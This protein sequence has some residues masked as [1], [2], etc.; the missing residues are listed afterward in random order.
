LYYDG[1]A[2]KK[3]FNFLAVFLFLII[4]YGVILSLFTRLIN[5]L[6]LFEQKYW[7]GN[8]I[9]KTISLL[10]AVF[11]LLT[12]AMPTNAYAASNDYAG[13]WAEETIQLWLNEGRITGYPDGSFKPNG[14]ITRAEFVTMVNKLFSFN[15]TTDINFSDV[16]EDDWYYQEVQKAFK[17]G[18]ITGVS[19]TQ[20]APN[21]NLTRE[22]AAVIVAK[23]MK[24]EINAEAAG[25]FT[26]NNKISNW[27]L[28]FVG[29]AA[30]SELIKGYTEDNTFKPQ[31][32]ITRAE[33]VVTL[34]RTIDSK[35]LTVDEAGTV[36]ENQ[37]VRN[38]YITKNVGDGDVTLKNVTVTGELLVEGGGLNT[39]TIEDSKI[40]KLTTNK[41]DGK[42]RILLKGGSEVDLTSILSGATLEQQDLTGDGFADVVIEEN[43]NK[44]QTITIKADIKE[45]SF[46]A[47]IKVNVVTGVIES[48]IIDEAA[49]DLI[50]D[51]G[52]GV[53]VLSAV[54]N[55]KVSFTGKGTIEK[56]EV[57]ADGVTFEKKPT[58]IIT[59]PPIGGGGGGGGNN[60]P[61][62]N[63]AVTGV[64]LDRGTM[65][66]T[67]GGATGTLIATVAPATATNKTVTWT[68]SNT[69]VATVANGV[70]TPISA[71]T[72]IITVTTADGSKTATCNITVNNLSVVNVTNINII[73]ASTVKFN[74]DISGAT[75]K[76]NGELLAEETVSGENEITVPLMESGINN[77]L[78]IEKPGYIKFETSNVVYTKPYDAV[79]TLGEWKKD[80][81]QPKTWEI[82]DNWI[83]HTTTKEKASNSWYDWQ[84]RG[85]V[86]N[87]GLTDKWKVETQIE[88]TD[89]LLYGKGVRTSLWIQVDGFGGAPNTQNNVL[90]WAIL[91][92]NNDATDPNNPIMGWESWDS[93][94]KWIPIKDLAVEKGIYTLTMIYDN[95][96][97]SQYIN[98]VL[99]REY[100]I[101]T[102]D[103][104]RGLTSPS[105]LIVQS[106]TFGDE[107]TVKWKV[108]TVEFVMPNINV[109]DVQVLNQS[110]IKF[111][112]D[113]SGAIIK[114][115]G[116]LIAEETVSGENNITVPLMESD[117]NN[118]LTLEKT[119]Y[120]KFE[121]GNVVYRTPYDSVA[122]LGE[123]NKDRTD[124]KTWKIVNGWITHTTN[125]ETASNSWYNWQGK[126]AFTSVGLSDKWKVETQVELTNELLNGT[127]VRTSL[128]IQVDG[129]NGVAN[130]QNNVLDWSILGYIND[131]TNSI[132][133][134][135][136]WDSEKGLWVTVDDVEVQEGIYTLT[137]IYDSGTIY[138]YINGVLVRD[139][140]IKTDDEYSEL[141]APSYLIVQSRTFG[142]EYTVNWKVPTVDYVSQYPVNSKFISTNAEL[143]EAINNQ[144]DNQT[145][146]IK[147]NKTEY[148]VPSGS[149][150]ISG[151][152]GWYLPITASNLSIIGIDN[153]IL[154]STETSANGAWASQ[155]FITVFGDNVTID[156]VKIK[157]KTEANKAIEVLGKDFK[158]KNSELLETAD[159]YS[160]A[161]YF[162]NPVKDEIKDM[163]NIV[164][165]NV[166]MTNS[167]VS[168]RDNAWGSGAMSGSLTFKDVT[169][170]NEGYGIPFNY[171]AIV[172]PDNPNG[173]ATSKALNVTADNL[174]IK[175]DNQYDLPYFS[176]F[177]QILKV[178]TKVE[179]ASGTYYMQEELTAP[180]GVVI[181][182]S[183]NNVEIIIAD[184]FVDESYVGIEGEHGKYSKLQLAIDAATLDN[185]SIY[186]ISDINI[187]EKIEV[188]N[189]ITIDGGGNTLLVTKDLG[190]DNSSKHALGIEA[191]NV[192]IKNLN[193]DNNALAYGV[194]AFEAQNVNLENLTIKDSKG[195]ALN[196]NG[197]HV[198]AFNLN[199]SGNSWGSV[200]VDP[201]KDVI[202]PSTFILTGDGIL[203]E[204][205]QIWSDGKYAIDSATVTVGAVGYSEYTV[206]RVRIW[207]NE[208]KEG[209]IT[210]TKDEITTSYPSIQL[211]VL[212]ATPG[213]TINV[214]AG[215]YTLPAN[216]RIIID[217][218]LSIIGA[219][220][221]ATK[222]TAAAFKDIG[223]SITSP[224]LETR[225]DDIV[226]SGIHFEWDLEDK[227][228]SGNGNAAV[229]AGTN[230][231]ISDNKFTIINSEGFPAVVMIGKTTGKNPLVNAGTINFTQ[232]EVVGSVSVVTASPSSS[233]NISIIDNDI[234]CTK[235]EGIWIDQ[236]ATM[237]DVFVISGNTIT[238]IPDGFKAIKLVKQVKSVNNLAAYTNKDIS[239][240]N[241]N[242][243]VELSY[244]PG[245]VY[246]EY[247][248]RLYALTSTG[249]GINGYGVVVSFIDF[250]LE[251]VEDLSISVCAANGEILQTNTLI[252]KD[253]SPDLE[254]IST[255]FDVSGTFDY[256]KD[257][258]W[259]TDGSIHGNPTV[260]EYAVADI[261]L[262]SGK[263]IIKEIEFWVPK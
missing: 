130:T 3:L 17:A 125:E 135:E 1:S 50:I 47:T 119:G 231:E 246:S 61:P 240:A 137:I 249:S 186:I 33:A 44:S 117:V 225:A 202:L 71:G 79:A 222:I 142:G 7:G 183:T 59:A 206:D 170:N 153:P 139:Y 46:K 94:G 28:D 76:W 120:V 55:A 114:W 193:I 157:S 54:V 237:N 168:Y 184:L 80:R 251:D 188:N 221:D 216:T 88:L 190:T 253:L 64:T 98:G 209:D 4:S 85:A 74:T 207:T 187:S 146:I 203:A 138:Q 144:Q 40:N 169:I 140:E 223:E 6:F 2:A 182:T 218:S 83:T 213:D 42:V 87:V 104:Y 160:G 248:S 136:S 232:N 121:T 178:G 105:C 72:A 260:P 116:E 171:G 239:D 200:N 97:M 211:A 189:S 69:S 84:G 155:N 91:Q 78:A 126:G 238:S 149:K 242:A 109:N 204:D 244:L 92:Y 43:A 163:G 250:T 220:K 23:V 174:V 192:T 243:T 208:V 103:E 110:S 113:I 56:A 235:M 194:L 36:V 145:W 185:N 27:A 35:D 25:I 96:I 161:L 58:E 14:N 18:Y 32:F 165:E 143:I 22:Q 180:E 214:A 70:V 11:M 234:T 31:N 132:K 147:G 159:G 195:A 164:I 229:F 77:T 228:P 241:N 108:P 112:T 89:E 38:L 86:T 259:E 48:I 198:S 219:G 128:W 158:L 205:N 166:K 124:P 152:S 179:L 12:M 247:P 167:D 39:V 227:S 210:I 9:R 148:D 10:L 258:Y 65:T 20:F 255:S 82:V 129:I 197:S 175:L 154:T 45:L 263:T 13:H 51:L 102:D 107:Y 261:T 156:G 41:A 49:E 172:N 106:R 224:M 256:E 196:V 122:T 230:V 141:T 252:K 226:I 99:V 81:T 123:W 111:N 115:N 257:G 30:K 262:E 217:K 201:G 37:T 134:W 93:T 199:T 16:N 75:I 67:V 29:A 52:E 173:G 90:D 57:N 24:L 73:N 101:E 60:N 5:I 66:L 21:S 176:D 68:S 34:N 131:P 215:T 118:I 8:M 245:E 53:K 177:F 181:D 212:A 236:T 162:T 19:E 150:I 133:S 151:Q 15:E 100:E 254:M 95:G 62:T 191:N 63:V 233:A 127:G 26:D